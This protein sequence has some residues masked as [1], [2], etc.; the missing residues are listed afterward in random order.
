MTGPAGRCAHF[1][2]TGR[3]QGVFF[4]AATEERARSLRL[5]GWV[6]NCENG[7]VELVACGAPALLAELERWLWQGPSA[8]RVDSVHREEQPWQAGTGFVVRR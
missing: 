5:S 1:R 6:R 3:V 4:R 7:D 8:A 2:V